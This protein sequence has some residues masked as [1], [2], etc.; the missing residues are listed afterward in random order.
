MFCTYCAAEVL[1]S[2]ANFCHSCGKELNKKAEASEV[3]IQ[4]GVMI[5][6]DGELATR[7]GSS[8]PL[9]V[10]SNATPKVLKAK[11]VAKQNHFISSLVKSDKALGYKLLYPDK[12]EVLRDFTWQKDLEFTPGKYKEELRKPYSR[13]RLYLCS[14]IDY[15]SYIADGIDSSDRFGG[16]SVEESDDSVGQRSSKSAPTL[17]LNKVCNIIGVYFPLINFINIFA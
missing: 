13:I 11:A 17:A 16:Q 1:S 2:A 9:K 8:L 10:P 15:L 7:R 6:K 4:I 3:T 5:W 14:N 12:S